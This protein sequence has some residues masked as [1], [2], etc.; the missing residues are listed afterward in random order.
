MMKYAGGGEMGSASV[1]AGIRGR[2]ERAAGDGWAS[3][4]DDMSGARWE[5]FRE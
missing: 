5:M 4:D 1:R 2:R 3:D